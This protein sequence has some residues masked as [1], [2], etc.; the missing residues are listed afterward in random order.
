MNS[1]TRRAPILDLERLPPEERECA[2]F[3]GHGLGN[4]ARY[5]DEVAAA[6]LL[7]GMAE[8]RSEEIVKTPRDSPRSR[9]FRDELSVLNH[10]KHIAARH[11]A[12][13]IYNFGKEMTGI[14]VNLKQCPSLQSAINDAARRAGAKLFAQYF[15]NFE[16][17]RNSAGHAGERN[18]PRAE[19]RH[20]PKDA[21]YILNSLFGRSFTT[22]VDEQIVQYELSPETTS[23]LGQVRDHF[24]NA[25]SPVDRFARFEEME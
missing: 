16:Q 11:G 20:R 6:D 21:P 9:E 7:L 12:F 10:W 17:V 1:D 13:T 25:F 8:F 14:T 2:E 18:S 3:I 4:L 5:C 15:P 23:R 24:W 19:Q 22:S